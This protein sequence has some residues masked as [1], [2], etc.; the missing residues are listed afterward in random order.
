MFSA[1]GRMGRECSMFV[2]NLIKRKE[3]LSVVTYGIRCKIS[4]AL[5]RN[6]LLCIR[7]SRKSNNEYEKLNEISFIKR[8]EELSDVTYGIRCKIS[9]ALLRNCL[10]CIRGSRKSNNEYESSMK[11]GL[12]L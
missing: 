9:F 10:L 8:K 2:K 6:C 11:Y 12:M 7:G 4:F 3:E 1:T 5:L